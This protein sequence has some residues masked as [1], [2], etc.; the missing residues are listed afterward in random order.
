MAGIFFT[1]TNAVTPGIGK[2]K[3]IEYL[4]ALQ[5]MN[6]VI[7][8]PA[9]YM[10]FICPI[11][12]VPL[13]TVFNYNTEPS[14]IFWLLLVTSI[15][16]SLGVFFITIL[17]NI[18]LNELL[19]KNNLDKFSLEDAGNLRNEIEKKWNNYN[20][21]RTITSSISLILLIIICFSITT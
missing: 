1:W 14:F 12:T 10:I 9:F 11:V 21:I 15:I 6:R 4:C 19:D 17:G 2:L 16:Y 5:S 8:N 7:L 20:F 3:D 13:A 18:P